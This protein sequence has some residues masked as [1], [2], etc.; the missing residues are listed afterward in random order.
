MRSPQPV[1]SNIS[2]PQLQSV[3]ADHNI[4]TYQFNDLGVNGLRYDLAVVCD[5]IQDFVECRT[6]DLLSLELAQWVRKVKHEAALVDLAHEQS[7]P[8]GIDRFWT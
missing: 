1:G 3:L 7:L 4:P 2:S 8:L 6:L 5:V